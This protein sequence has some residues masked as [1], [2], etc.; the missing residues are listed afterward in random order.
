MTVTQ[1][2]RNHPLSFVDGY[3]APTLPQHIPTAQESTKNFNID[4]VDQR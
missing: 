3:D 1:S 4:I 2:R